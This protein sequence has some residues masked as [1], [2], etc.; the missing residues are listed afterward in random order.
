MDKKQGPHHFQV[1]D[2]VWLYLDKRRFKKNIHH[3]LKPLRYGPYAIIQQIGDNAFRSDISS[4]LGI[5]DVINTDLLKLYEDSTLETNIQYPTDVL[6]ELQQPLLEDTTFDRLIHS[7]G[8]P[9][10]PSYLVAKHDQFSTPVTNLNGFQ[11]LNS[12]RNFQ[13]R[14]KHWSP[15][16]L[17]FGGIK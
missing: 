12:R 2:K 14:G 9:S 7:T 4:H 17:P 16:L 8:T 15:M 13:K 5:H 10:L 1:G 6:L 3:K 11:S